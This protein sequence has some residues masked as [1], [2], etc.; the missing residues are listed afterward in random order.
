MKKTIVV[1]VLIITMFLMMACGGTSGVSINCIDMQESPQEVQSEI[2]VLTNTII[3]SIKEND[4]QTIMSIASEAFV[5]NSTGI[6]AT[7]NSFYEQ[8]TGEPVLLSEY[9]L[10]VSDTGTNMQLVSPKDTEDAFYVLPA[11]EQ[12]AISFFTIVNGTQTNLLAQ[13]FVYEDGWKLYGMAMDLYAIN[14]MN[15]PLLYEEALKIQESGDVISA[16]LYA[17]MLNTV[18]VPAGTI[19]YPNVEEMSDYITEVTQSVNEQYEMP[20]QIQTTSGTFDIV[21]I[22]ASSKV[23]GIEC[24][25]SYVSQIELSEENK[26]L[27]VQEAGAIKTALMQIAPG[28]DLYFDN[29]IANIFEEMPTDTS[30]E[31]LSYKV[32]IG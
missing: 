27:F 16:A 17:E 4:S 5:E 32:V 10:E 1:S 11:A 19:V 26:Q 30:K 12:M 13:A 7:I 31:Y 14:G 3:N 8:A 20:M 15:A 24:M 28:L 29:I 6:E 22:E 18:L 23:E 25:I 21:S 2:T 9:Y